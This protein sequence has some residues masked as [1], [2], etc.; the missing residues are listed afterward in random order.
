MAIEKVE[1]L[2]I[3]GGQAGLAMSG[4]L[5][6]RGAAH[7]VVERRRI[8]ERWRSERW[9]SLVANGPAWHDRFPD[10]TFDDID[11]DGFAPAKAIVDYFVAYADQIAAPVRCGVEVT[12]LSQRSGGGFRAETSS[13]VIDAANVVLATGPFQR[14]V[15]PALVPAAADIVQIHSSTYR[16]PA[17]LPDGAVLVIGAGSSGV[18]IADELRR[19]GRSVYLSVGPHD[20]PP[21]R[22]RGHDF[23]WWLGALGLWDAVAP[24]AEHVTIAVSGARGGHTVDFRRLAADGVTLLGTAQSFADGAMSFGADLARNVARGDANLLAML[25]AADA[26]AAREGLDLPDDPD[27]RGREPDPACLTDPVLQVNL[28]DASVRSIIWATGYTLDFSWVEIDVFDAR[29]RPIQERGVSGTPGLYFLGL[30]WLSRRSSAFIWGVWRDADYLADHI[31]M[32]G[33][34]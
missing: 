29:G 32:R 9:D 30:P 34:V 2:I 8:A 5:G 28:A 31:A 21:R 33:A 24:T 19:A 22:Y 16:N 11:P 6:A 10:K 14:P 3:G 15:I 18:Q 7:L 25:D 27:A 1:T 20:R 12:T 4:R 17:Q 13:G 26:Y 23:C